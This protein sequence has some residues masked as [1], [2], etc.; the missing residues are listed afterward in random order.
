[1]FDIQPSDKEVLDRIGKQYI[2][3]VCPI[4]EEP[5]DLD[6]QE[7]DTKDEAAAV[8]NETAIS[9]EEAVEAKPEAE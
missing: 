6:E 8:E 4:K 9:G 3:Y 2:K 1:M 7:E 5:I